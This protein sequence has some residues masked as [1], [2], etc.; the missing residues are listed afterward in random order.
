MTPASLAPDRERR[1]R[2][3]WPCSNTPTL[4][5]IVPFHR[6]LIDLGR[7]LAALAKL[8]SGA[9]VIV[10]ADG[11]VDDCRLL[12]KEAGARLLE[13]PGP[14]GPAI[15]RNRGAALARGDVLVF[16]DSDVVVAPDALAR[17]VQGFRAQPHVQAI[18]GTYD[19]VPG[20]LNFVSQYKNLAHAFVHRS[21]STVAATFW[22]GLGAI[23]TRAFWSVGG[24][25]ERFPRPC[26]E[27]IDL[28]YRLH[29]RG[30]PIRLDYELRGCHLKRW[31]FMAMVVSDVLDRG[32]PWTQ[33]I[34]RAGR[35]H[36]DLNLKSAYR[37]SVALAYALLL[38]LG[39]AVA[40]AAWL[41]AAIPII[42]A[43][44]ILNRRFYGFFVR[45]KGLLFA[46]RLVPLHYLY[47]LYNGV[48]FALGTT[49][50]LA[51]RLRRGRVPGALPFTPWSG[52]GTETW[53]V[54]EW[55][56]KEAAT[57]VE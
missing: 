52:P 10:V 40:N 50:Y 54:R 51:A 55:Q 23:R 35:V 9:E 13:I 14:S 4:S 47:H 19:D 21:S 45:T 20:S 22:S 33:V 53:D 18:F 27:D 8:P 43:L 2:P 15:A 3:R 25:D 34:M 44:F 49:I 36:N 30:C 11:A 6:N 28:G 7:C 12:V 56:P 37:V 24:F 31:T 26:I 29:A 1:R 57:G 38:G 17:I 39:L 46:L 48:S 16:V 41:Y 32:I 42:A 5:I